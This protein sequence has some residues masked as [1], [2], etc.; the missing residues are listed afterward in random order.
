MLISLVEQRIEEHYQDHQLDPELR[1]EIE[2]TLLDELSSLRQATDIENR[3]LTTQK[4]R[5]TKERAR[6]LQAH[7]AGAVPLDLLKSEQDRIA[8]HLADIDERLL[9]IDV[10]FNKIETCLR[11]ALDYAT[12]SYKAYMRAGAQERRLLNQAFFS[13][14]TVHD[15]DIEVEL[16][17]PFRTLFSEELAMAAYV[18]ASQG[19]AL[20]QP[21][22]PPSLTS[23]LRR[24][25]DKPAHRVDAGLKETTLVELRGLEPL[26]PTLPVWCATSCAIAPSRA[27]RSYT[28]ANKRS[29]S[30]FRPPRRPPRVPPGRAPDGSACAFRAPAPTRRR[31]SA[32]RLR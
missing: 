25:N 26:T 27:H 17:E 15:D 30:Q 28:T 6:L 12:H 21:D 20:Q 31:R 3:S 5:L 4:E 32:R 19:P 22:G 18:A 23:V 9:V 1:D 29:K 14:I 7:Y 16:S 13:R 24:G 2:A 10:E 8:R 11:E